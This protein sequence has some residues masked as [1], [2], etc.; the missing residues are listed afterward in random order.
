MVFEEIDDNLWAVI[1]PC[2]PR[3][4]PKTGRPRSDLRKLL[5]GVLFALKTGCAWS[6]IPRTYGSKSTIHRFHL[7]LCKK[8]IYKKIFDSM[9]SMGYN[10]DMI[11]ISRCC[12]DT[13]SIEAKKGEI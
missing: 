8:G 12:I 6:D 13:K 2:L 11:D 4:K 3:E 5:N 10:T 7:E 1:K 9:L